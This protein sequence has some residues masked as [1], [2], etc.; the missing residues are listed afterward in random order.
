MKYR[1]L[2]FDLDGTLFDYGR[3]EAAALQM[4]CTQSGIQYEQAYLDAYTKINSRIWKEYEQGLVSQAELKIK[5]FEL[6]AETIGISLNARQFSERYLDNMS[7]QTQLIDGADTIISSLAELFQLV[8]ITNG[9]TRV[10]RSRIAKSALAPFFEHIIIS[11]DV[12][13]SKPDSKIFDIT[14]QQINNPLKQEVLL[15]GDSL[16]S[17]MTGGANYGIDTCWFNR[18][19]QV[20]DIGIIPTYEIQ[21]LPELLD[22]VL[23]GK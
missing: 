9:L 18:K 15:I 7:R 4:T 23:I 21:S 10:Q 14:F 8:L 22:I 1:V 17:D 11:E 2:L 6:F 20:N 12:G 3:A 13:C 5:R 16:T 19:G